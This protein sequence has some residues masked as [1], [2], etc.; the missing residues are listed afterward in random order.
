MGEI[1]Q[2]TVWPFWIQLICLKELYTWKKGS[3]KKVWEIYSPFQKKI[4]L[5]FFTLIA[6]ICRESNF[7]GKSSN[8]FKIGNK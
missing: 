6:D 2:P 5:S 4:V 1:P 3:E 8:R 7:L